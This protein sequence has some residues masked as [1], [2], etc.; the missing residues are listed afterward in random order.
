MYHKKNGISRREA[1]E[2]LLVMVAAAAGLDKVDAKLFAQTIVRASK[3]NLKF[4]KLRLSGFD[5]RIFTSE[6]GRTTPLVSASQIKISGATSLATAKVGPSTKI[7]RPGQSVQPGFSAGA[8]GCQVNFAGGMGAGAADCPGFEV[9]GCFSDNGGSGCSSLEQCDNNVCSSQD[10]GGEGAGACHGVN[11]CNSQDCGNLQ[12]CG[13]NECTDQTCPSLS[14]CGSNKRDIAGLINQYRND[15]FI[16]DLMK[17]VNMTNV[18]QLAVQ[19]ESMIR[20][21][22]TLNVP[23][24]PIR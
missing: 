14:G 19:V 3:T 20:N 8:M 24:T 21:R 7:I 22:R 9:C 4:L 5:S 13:D 15:P 23:A 12:V 18:N 2:R 16:Q 11:D 17:Q 1:M 10:F 6:F